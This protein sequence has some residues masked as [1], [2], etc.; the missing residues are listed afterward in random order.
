M[1]RRLVL[2]V[3]LTAMAATV[4]AQR[5]PEKG[6]PTNLLSYP[7]VQK[8]LGLSVA[9]SKKIADIERASQ[10]RYMA[11]LSPSPSNPQNVKQ[12]TQAQM[13]AEL[14]RKDAELLAL[15]NA[16][17]KKRLREI[18]VQAMGAFALPA[19]ELSVALSITPAQKK[20]LIEAGNA[21]RK[22]YRN[23][24]SRLVQPGHV[25]P[26][27]QIARDKVGQQLIAARM[28]MFKKVDAAANAILTRQQKAKWQAMKGRPFPVETLLGPPKMPR[29]HATRA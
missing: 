8:D 24:T 9:A 3:C 15:L 1:I 17:Q 25:T 21:A 12:P 26:K 20:K 11:M 23:T 7:S 18:G 5:A 27:N 28:Q 13:M 16:K 22:D 2:F 6:Y 19:P 4:N 29:A 10:K 14:K